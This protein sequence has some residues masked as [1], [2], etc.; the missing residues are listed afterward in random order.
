MAKYFRL[1][2]RIFKLSAMSEMAYRENFWTWAVIHTISLATLVIFF[3]IVY[4]G[5]SSIN[6][7][8]RYESLMVLG[9]GTL[10]TGL[11]SLTFFP[12][13]YDFSRKIISGELD[14]RIIKPVDLL[15][16]SAFCWVD[17]EDAIVVPNSLLLIGY[18]LYHLQPQ[19]LG[20]NIG[21]FVI[22]LFSS[23]LILF[24]ILTL[25]QSLA[26]KYVKVQSATNFYWSIVN[27][28]KYPAKAIKNISLLATI[29]LIP[30]AIISSVPAEVLFGRF[31]WAWILGSL[32]SA[33]TLFVISR[34]VFYS[35]LRHYS[36]AS[37]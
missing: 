15:F 25:I 11:G 16:Q 27:I 13:M 23:L 29:S 28:G 31:D 37:S 8:T 20:L 7:W 5:T 33:V 4:Q 26:F 3:H 14:G 19:N 9:V 6:G 1:Y 30:L 12:F 2:T 18:A 17:M 10:I 21:L 24:S 22:L 32:V 36:S 34:R 35:S